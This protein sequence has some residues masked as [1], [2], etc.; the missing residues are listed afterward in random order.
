[1]LLTVDIGNTNVVVGIFDGEVLVTS[2][3]FETEWGKMPDEW[4]ALL[5][6][7]AGQEGIDLGALDGAAIGSGVPR[8]TT[9]FS[10]MI[11]QRLGSPPVEVSAAID[12]P[13]RV[14]TDYPLEVGPDRLENAVAAHARG[15]GPWVV[16]DLGTATTLDVISADGDYL[17]GPI[18]PGIM[19]A[20][21]ALTGR[22]A[23]LSAVPLA[24][25]KRAIGRNTVECIQAGTVLGYIGLIEG[26]LARITAE[27]GET[28]N[29]IAT[30]GLGKLFVGNTP[31]IDAYEPDLTLIGLR[32]IYEHVQRGRDLPPLAR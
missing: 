19:V 7:L 27:L 15:R 23:R 29:V 2:W 28:P 5:A 1:M 24:M 30:G 9:A 3:R 12:L 32:L 4:W 31:S 22:A 13:I 21:E 16:V 11:V 6:T 18:A 20:M 25:P 26:L 10:E 17:G 14:R 8:L